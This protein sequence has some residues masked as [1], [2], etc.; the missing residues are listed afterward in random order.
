MFNQQ[1]S[2]NPPPPPAT[3]PAPPL[4]L[5]QAAPQTAAAAVSGTRGTNLSLTPELLKRAE[6]E[7]APKLAASRKPPDLPDYD[8]GAQLANGARRG[9][10]GAQ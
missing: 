6:A 2:A 4:Q 10:T 7:M 8:L 5:A 3:M 1:A 9:L